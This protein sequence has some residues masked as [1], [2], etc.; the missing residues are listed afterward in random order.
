MRILLRASTICLVFLI[1]Y[2]S[3]CVADVLATCT[4]HGTACVRWTGCTK[5]E[6]C[7]ECYHLGSSGG[8]ELYCVIS[9]CGDGVSVFGECRGDTHYCTDGD[10]PG[11]CGG[12]S[13]FSGETMVSTPDGGK[14]IQD[15]EQG[16]AISSYDPES[17]EEGTS[18]VEKIYETTQGAYYKI[19][20][21]DGTEVKVTAEHPMY[22]VQK[23]EE[24][25]NFWEYLKT[26]SMIRNLINTISNSISKF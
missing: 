1:V 4:T 20:T 26:E 24:S 8:E 18:E 22:A 16:D 12:S 21:K 19:K 7:A 2:F 14:E 11:G 10:L 23:T 6:D 3:F 13:C 9:S 25:K 15:V 17:G 5:E